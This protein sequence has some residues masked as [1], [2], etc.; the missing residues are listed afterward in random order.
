MVCRIKP[1]N[2][3]EEPIGIVIFNLDMKIDKESGE[4]SIIQLRQ[5]TTK[6]FTFN[7]IYTDESQK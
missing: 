5:E 6:T 2:N 1:L 4:I 3:S 7:R